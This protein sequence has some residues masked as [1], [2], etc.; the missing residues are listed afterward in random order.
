MKPVPPGLN[1]ASIVPS[2]DNRTN[3]S[4]QSVPLYV[5]KSP[6]TKMLPSDRA[7]TVFTVL[8]KPVP[9]I[10]NPPLLLFNDNLTMILLRI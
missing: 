5:V 2:V 6:P 8:L 10:L 7:T 4:W 3:L 1:V 9:P